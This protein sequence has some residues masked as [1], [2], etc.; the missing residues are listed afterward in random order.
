[1]SEISEVVVVG[2]GMFGSAAAKHLSNAGAQVLVIGPAE[3]AG[4]VPASQHEFGAYFDE[5]RITRRLGWDEV[6]G[7]TDA[8]SLERFPPGHRREAK[9][10]VSSRSRRPCQGH[11]PRL[12]GPMPQ[13]LR[14]G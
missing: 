10:L 9:P 12:R 1:M 7:T 6:W 8:R 3:P 4:G 11:V 5:A 13:A 2:A 14:R